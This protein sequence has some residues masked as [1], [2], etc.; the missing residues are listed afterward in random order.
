MF[1]MFSQRFRSQATR[2]SCEENAILVVLG[3][4]P[5]KIGQNDVEKVAK[6]EFFACTTKSTKTH[7]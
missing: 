2:S 6:I 5:H 4:F 7:T 1:R 3:R